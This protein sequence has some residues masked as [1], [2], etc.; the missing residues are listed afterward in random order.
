MS[1]R[2]GII[3]CGGIAKSHAAGYNANN[4][5]ITAVTD[6]NPE[7]A[8]AM[9]AETGAAVFASAEEL[10]NSGA[11]DVVSICTPPIAHEKDTIYA[12][13]K[14]INVLLEKPAA[15]DAKSARNIKEAADKSSAKLMLAFRHRYVPAVVKMK[16][17][18][19]AGE[20]GSIVFFHNTFCGPAFAMKDKWFSKKA[21]AGGGSML[22]TSSHSVDLF[23]FLVGEVTEQHAV[24]HTHF[25]GTDVEDAGIITV[26]AENGAIGAL[27][28]AWVAGTGKADILIMG[29]KGKLEYAYFGDLTL[30]MNGKDPEKIELPAFSGG[31]NE[32]IASFV[33]AINGSELE[34]N[35]LDGLRCLEIINACYE[36]NA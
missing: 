26:K 27:T 34:I 25:N 9:A 16:E 33:K 4:I 3:G 6:L 28:S 30:H 20:I 18:I 7:A 24:Y 29:Q 23:R 32:Q 5:T 14:G 11:V 31:F 8:N 13:E 17:L 21:V 10:L 12:L 22:D 35:A 36:E 15:F 19:D 1:L 2:A